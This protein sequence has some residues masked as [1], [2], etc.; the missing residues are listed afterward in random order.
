[1]VYSY[2]IG[3]GKGLDKAKNAKH[4]GR[5]HMSFL[6]IRRQGGKGLEGRVKSKHRLSFRYLFTEGLRGIPIEHFSYLDFLN[7]Y[8]IL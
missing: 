2:V 7:H 8:E 4:E 3:A 1:M 5:T 6:V